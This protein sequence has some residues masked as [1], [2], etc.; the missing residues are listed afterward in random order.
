[1]LERRRRAPRRQGRGFARRARRRAKQRRFLVDS[2]AISSPIPRAADIKANFAVPGQNRLAR[3]YPAPEH[4]SCYVLFDVD[5]ANENA[6]EMR[7]TLEVAG[8]APLRNLAV[9]MDA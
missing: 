9:P 5:L 6:C 8:R 7:L 3:G 2:A 4:K 1:M